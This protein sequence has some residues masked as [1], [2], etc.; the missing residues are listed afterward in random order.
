MFSLI[1]GHAFNI[2]R[3]QQAQVNIQIAQQKSRVRQ[4]SEQLDQLS[5][6]QLNNLFQN[7]K[8]KAPDRD[9]ASPQQFKENILTEVKQKQKTAQQTLETTISKQKGNLFKK[10]FKWSIGAIVSG[11]SFILIWRHTKWTRV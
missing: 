11:I 8:Q 9:I 2:N 3:S 1:V 5:E 6:E 7:Y 10:T 4:Y